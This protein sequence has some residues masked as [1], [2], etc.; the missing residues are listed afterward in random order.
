MPQL[1]VK[2]GPSTHD[3]DLIPVCVNTNEAFAIRS[4]KFEGKIVVH[5]QGLPDEDGNVEDGRYFELRQNVTWSIQVQ[6]V[7]KAFVLPLP[8]SL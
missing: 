3:R 2:V 4:D 5:I 6:G 1:R 8:P 7:S